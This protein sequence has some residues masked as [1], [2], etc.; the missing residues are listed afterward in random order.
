VLVEA[1]LANLT[2]VANREV[3]RVDF[4]ERLKVEF[5]G[6]VV[7][8]DAVLHPYRELD[9]APDLSVTAG[10]KL[11]D[12]CTGKNGRY[13]LSGPF[14]QSVFDRLAGYED[15]NDAER[16]RHAPAMRRKL[17]TAS[18]SLIPTRVDGDSRGIP[19]S[20]IV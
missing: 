5:R 20:A 6:S 11:A 9:D 1:A 4:A 2:G 12:V 15:L 19:E 16:L 8:P 3:L 14:R 13:A 7:T 17:R 18:A 10:E